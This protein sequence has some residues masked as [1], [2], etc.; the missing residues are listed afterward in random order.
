[1]KRA[2]A[3][4]HYLC[5]RIAVIYRGHIVEIGTAQAIIANPRHPYT[6]ALLDALPEYGHHGLQKKFNTL[7]TEERV[8]DHSRGCPFFGR[9]NRAQ[10]SLCAPNRPELRSLGNEHQVAC[11]FAEHDK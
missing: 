10:E 3:A 1:M 9:C 4:A 2:S 6:Q 8:A 7:R 11:F 5:H